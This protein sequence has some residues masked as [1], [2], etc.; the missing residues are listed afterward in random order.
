MN[1]PSC[2][3]GHEKRDHQRSLAATRYGACKICLCN[4]YAKPATPAASDPA[5]SVPVAMGPAKD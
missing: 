5:V 3:C 2:K 4:E 1:K